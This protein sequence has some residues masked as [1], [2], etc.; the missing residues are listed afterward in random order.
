MNIMF[1]L[2]LLSAGPVAA[3]DLLARLVSSRLRH[4]Q[5]SLACASLS[6]VDPNDYANCVLLCTA[7]EATRKAACG[8]ST[9]DASCQTACVVFDLKIDNSYANKNNGI[10][11]NDNQKVKTYFK[12]TGCT[13][14]WSGSPASKSLLVA[15]DHWGRYNVLHEGADSAF[16]VP[17]INARKWRRFDLFL[18]DQAG[19]VQRDVL[20]LD[21]PVQCAEEPPQQLPL[22]SALRSYNWVLLGTAVPMLGLIFIAIL[23]MWQRNKASK[24]STKNSTISSI[25]SISSGCESNSALPKPVFLPHPPLGN[26]AGVKVYENYSFQ[27]YTTVQNC[28]F[29]TYV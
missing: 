29:N 20:R 26:F 5:C 2:S 8:L 18:V 19:G 7:P 27:R 10:I 17:Q 14:Q 12:V 11:E 16:T 3:G 15:Q 28:P 23:F 1:T 9:C 6:L 4:A 22:E 24:S 13:V 21:T 25:P